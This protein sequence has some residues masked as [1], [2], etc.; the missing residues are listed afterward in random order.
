[1]NCRQCKTEL[2]PCMITEMGATEETQWKLNGELVFCCPN[3]C[4]TNQHETASWQKRMEE[5]PQPRILKPA[6]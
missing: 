5:K 2:V 1:M 3:G 4:K 6:L